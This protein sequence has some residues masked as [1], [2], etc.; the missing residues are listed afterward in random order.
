MTNLKL[1]EIATFIFYCHLQSLYLLKAE[2]EILKTKIKNSTE[3][4]C[5]SYSYL[6]CQSEPNML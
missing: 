2:D 3:K 1:Q 4:K 6:I 5:K